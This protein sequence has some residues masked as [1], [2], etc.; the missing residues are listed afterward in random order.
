MSTAGSSFNHVR[1]SACTSLPSRKTTCFVD[2]TADTTCDICDIDDTGNTC[3]I[4]DTSDALSPTQTSILSASLLLA[5]A[6]SLASRSEASLSFLR[7]KDYLTIT[8]LSLVELSM[9]FLLPQHLHVPQNSLTRVAVLICVDGSLGWHFADG[10]G[11]VGGSDWAWSE[12]WHG[13]VPAHISE[14]LLDTHLV[15]NWRC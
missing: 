2:D 5:L 3:D 14:E 1:A 6:F 11:G 8:L 13:A 9:L 10:E 4:G 15:G 12:I 7:I